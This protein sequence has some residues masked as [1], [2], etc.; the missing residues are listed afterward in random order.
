MP[1]LCRLIG[2]R[3]RKGGG[4]QSIIAVVGDATARYRL[5]MPWCYRCEHYI[6]PPLRLNL[7]LKFFPDRP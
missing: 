6:V 4:E 3:T 2:H 5:K 1:V 7:V